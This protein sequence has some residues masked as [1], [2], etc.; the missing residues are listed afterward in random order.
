ML[1]LPTIPVAERNARLGALRTRLTGL[2]IHGTGEPSHT[3]IDEACHQFE[4][5]TL[6][7][8]EPAKCTS[9]ELEVSSGKEDKKLKLDAHSL[10][11]KE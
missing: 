3:L 4:T 2:N 10:T 7:Y 1:P 9:R 11:V 8:I 6:K 5:R